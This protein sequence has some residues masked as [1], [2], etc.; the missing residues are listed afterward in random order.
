MYLPTFWKLTVENQTHYMRH[1]A[2][3]AGPILFFGND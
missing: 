2:P 1:A 3:W